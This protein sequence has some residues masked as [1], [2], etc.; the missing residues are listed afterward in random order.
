MNQINRRT[1]LKLSSAGIASLVFPFNIRCNRIYE[2]NLPNIIFIMADDMGYG[3]VG[4]YNPESKIPTPNMNRI[5]KEGVRFTDAHTPSAVCTPTRYGVLTGRYCWRT[6]LKSGV[7][8]GYNQPLIEPERLTVASLLKK[9]GYETACIGKWHLGLKW[10]TKGGKQPE[11]TEPYDQMNIDFTKPIKS[12]PN[13]LGFD[14]FFG[15]AGCTTDDPPLCFIENDHTVGIPNMISP[16]D[17]ANEGRTLLMVPGWKHEE[18]DTT[19]TK[20]AIKFIENH[21]KR[22]PDKPFFLYF[23]TSVPH[24]PWLP[25]D[26]VKGKSKAGPRGDQVVLFDWIV[27]QIDQTL[28]RL[29]LKENTLLIITSDNGPREGVNGHKSTGNW[30]G[31]KGG[32][33][34]GGHRVPFIARWPGKIRPGSISNETICLTDLMATC[35]A[36]IG[37]KLPD[38]AGEDSYNILPAL[39][40]E[41]LNHPIREAIVHHSGA[42]VFAIRQGPWKLIIGTKGAGYD[43]GPQSDSIVQLYNLKDD[44]AERHDLW[45]KHPEIVKRL[46]KLLEK[47][48]REG[49]SR[50]L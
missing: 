13:A 44:P 37:E 19:F 45:D 42:G 50:H 38:N 15:T 33:W 7:F 31:F 47:Y 6:W 39:M 34:E 25:P 16:I 3:D 8:G 11:P 24:I 36:I 23:P 46:K 49:H 22:Q 4:C 5:A 40:G 1:F 9:Y 32:I 26:F 18:A 10:A 20:K 29:N 21:V 27:G 30:R 14:Y 43:K 17:T 48:Q 2:E 12:G 28:K 35:A 41:K